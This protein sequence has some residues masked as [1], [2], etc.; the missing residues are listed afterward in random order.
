MNFQGMDP[1]AGRGTAAAVKTAGTA[2]QGAFSAL[3]GAVESV[4]WIGPD[5]ETFVG[6]WHGFIAQTIDPLVQ[7]ITE[8]GEQLLQHAEQQ[9]QASAS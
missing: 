9:D 5:R 2:I 7:A 4:E 1:E 8:K 3:R 6:D